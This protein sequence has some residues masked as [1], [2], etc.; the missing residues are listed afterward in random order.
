MSDT[1]YRIPVIKLWDN[2][3]VSLQGEIGDDVAR[4]LCDE[5]LR[6]IHNTHATG[7]VIDVTGVWLMDS[8]LCA[9]LTMI[10]RSARLI[11]TQTIISG[12]NPEIAITLQS[13]GA[14]LQGARTALTLEQALAM[15]GIVAGPRPAPSEKGALARRG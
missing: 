7:L 10:A 5:I 8:H 14:E 15:L 12:M 4:E 6:N 13:M 2:I 3:L 11:G 1:P 9:I